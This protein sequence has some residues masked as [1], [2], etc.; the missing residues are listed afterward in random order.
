ML[1]FAD[2]FWWW[3]QGI[4][5]PGKTPAPVSSQLIHER[6]RNC[7]AN[8]NKNMSFCCAACA[9]CDFEKI[10]RKQVSSQK[11]LF[12]SGVNYRGFHYVP[13]PHDRECGSPLLAIP[14]NQTAFLLFFPTFPVA[15][16]VSE[17][18]ALFPRT[19]Q[20]LWAFLAAASEALW[21]LLLQRHRDLSTP[22]DSPVRRKPWSC[23]AVQFDTV[24]H[25]ISK[26][27]NLNFYWMLRRLHSA[28][29]FILE[30][31]DC[32]WSSLIPFWFVRISIC[33]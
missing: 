26:V 2:P 5:W 30:S 12:D 19:L 20:V 9:A 28:V 3:L 7:Q 1:I 4:C 32:P 27:K 33:M 31:C 15:G 18:D 22:N 14:L 29:C 16:R 13:R 6:P 17:Y 8:D 25:G 21:A 24:L 23:L 10:Y 11:Q